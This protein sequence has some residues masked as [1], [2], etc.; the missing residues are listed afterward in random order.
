MR[1]KK[2]LCTVIISLSTLLVPTLAYGQAYG[3][4]N[5]ET[6]NLRSNPSTSATNVGQLDQSEEVE[7]VG[8]ANN[9]WLEIVTGNGN[10]AYVFS[11]YVS[12]VDTE[13]TING[14]GVRL[15]DYPDVNNSQVFDTLYNG[16]KVIIE[17]TVD[18]WCKVIAKGKE[19]FISKD[20]VNSPFINEV[21]TK[22]MSE[23]ERVKP[24]QVTTA[25]AESNKNQS[26]KPQQS[27][28]NSDKPVK[29]SQSGLGAAIVEDALQFKGGRYV[30]GGNNLNTGVDCSGFTQQIMKRHGIS[31]SRSSRSQY[32]NDGYKVSKDNLQ[33]GDLLFYG[34]NGN[35]SHVA[36]YIGNGQVIHANTS[37]TGI[38]VS[39]AFNAGKPYIGAKR[40]I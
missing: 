18:N 17:Y 19:G 20:F 1:F 39:S 31:I 32:A 12:I 22:K 16:D 9:E 2:T 13:G 4:V 23:V 26:Q 10:K 8:R 11:K 37:S 35:V 6:L 30:Y 40:V 34:Y 5:V 36:L 25:K 3:K 21:T 38:I 33:K 29:S 24:A 7:I 27:T 15:R 14:Q 28:S